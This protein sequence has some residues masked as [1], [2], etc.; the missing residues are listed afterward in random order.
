[1]TF[2]S[3]VWTR[4]WG[5]DCT[6]VNIPTIIYKLQLHIYKRTH[7]AI[8]PPAI[9]L[10]SSHEACGWH[11][12]VFSIITYLLPSRKITS[13]PWTSFSQGSANK[14]SACPPA[15]WTDRRPKIYWETL[16]LGKRRNFLLRDCPNDIP[17][18]ITGRPPHGRVE[19]VLPLRVAHP[20]ST[21]SRRGMQASH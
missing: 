21:L 12:S 20:Y 14:Y 6:L 8:H 16:S 18:P 19:S 9:T 11:V 1:M 10:L 13:V 7:T 2:E 3:V 15:T 4:I 17:I 5:K